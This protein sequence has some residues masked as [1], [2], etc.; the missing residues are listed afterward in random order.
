MVDDALDF[1]SNYK[2][3]PFT[4]LQPWVRYLG[5]YLE[6]RNM[7]NPHHH[8]AAIGANAIAEAKTDQEEEARDE[9]EAGFD[10]VFG[11]GGSVVPSGSL[12]QTSISSLGTPG[13]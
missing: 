11:E 3:R 9:K 8:A 2:Q 12:A 4:A 10:A 7:T 1:F 6:G 13:F 5:G